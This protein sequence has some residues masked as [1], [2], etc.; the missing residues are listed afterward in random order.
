MSARRARPAGTR[1][2]TSTTICRSS[3]PDGVYQIGEDLRI[4]HRSR[5]YRRLQALRAQQFGDRGQPT[6]EVLYLQQRLAYQWPVPR[7]DPL[8]HLEFRAL[9]VDLEQVD[10]FVGEEA[11]QPV[12]VHRDLLG[13]VRLLDELGAPLLAEHRL[14]QLLLL[15]VAGRVARCHRQVRERHARLGGPA[16]G[17]LVDLD[18]GQPVP[19]DVPAQQRGRRGRGFEREYPGLR[20]HSLDVQQEQ[21]DMRPD[22]DDERP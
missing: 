5:L 1:P 13:G 10:R 7:L 20:A 11:G 17:D 8:Q 14:L 9:H 21:A 16:Q 3:T 19:L 4:D 6:V 12:D 2:T 15:R 18:V 22:V